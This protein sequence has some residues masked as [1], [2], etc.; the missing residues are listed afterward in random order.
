MNDESLSPYISLCID[1]AKRLDI[2]PEQMADDL[3]QVFE[4]GSGSNN[5]AERMEFITPV[6]KRLA[7]FAVEKL[8][9]LGKKI[10]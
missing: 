3:I 8:N 6:F 10:E 9:D 2:S 1:Y 7:S 4:S 5:I